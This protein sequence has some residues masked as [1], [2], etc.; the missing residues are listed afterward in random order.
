MLG[1][2]LRVVY[3][4]Y[5][6]LCVLLQETGGRLQEL[7]KDLKGQ[8]KA[9]VRVAAAHK[10]LKET[11]KTEEKKRKQLQKSVADVSIVYIS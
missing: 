7:E 11:V 5:C 8:E 1:I 3:I 6:H 4:P 10:N 2:D 9:E